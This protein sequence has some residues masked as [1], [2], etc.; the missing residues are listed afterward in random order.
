MYYYFGEFKYF[1]TIVINELS[2]YFKANPTAI[3][4]I[5]TYHDYAHILN[6]L[7]SKNVQVVSINL[8]PERI[9]HDANIN[10]SHP[11]QPTNLVDFL[12][13]RTSLSDY[14]TNIN[15]TKYKAINKYKHHENTICVLPYYRDEFQKGL[16]FSIRN[17]TIDKYN[18][19]IEI[20]KDTFFGH[21]YNIVLV[22]NKN[23]HLKNIDNK[24][25][26]VENIDEM[27][28]LMNNCKLLVS[29]ECGF[30]EFAKNCGVSNILL[31]HTGVYNANNY[32]YNPHNSN[33]YNL[34]INDKLTIPRFRLDYCYSVLRKPQPKSARPYVSCI[35]PTYNRREFLP[36]LCE[37]FNMQTY[38]NNSKELIIIDDSPQNNIDIIPN[39]SNIRYYHSL[40]KMTIGKKRNIINQLI[41][42]DIVVCF[43]D[44][45]YYPVDRISHA[46]TKLQGAKVNLAGATVI[47]IYYTDL[48][49]IY[50]FGPY[51]P[52][53]GTN[54]TMAYTI[55]Q[56]RD[57]HYDDDKPYAEEAFF[58]SN[59]T[60][61][62]V[63][64][65]PHKVML[66][67]AHGGNTFN[68]KKIIKDGK[69]QKIKLN[70]F[71]KNKKLL[72]FYK[73][74]RLK[75]AE[76]AGI[77]PEVVSVGTDN[78][79]VVADNSNILSNIMMVN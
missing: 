68:K 9:F 23:E 59:F 67:M 2:I 48:D 28:Y 34:N 60:V 42:G 31:I 18:K 61:P 44:D 39:Q 22:G 24:L 16:D 25:Q 38:P 72:K 27:I 35:C 21:D 32:K 12:K 79:T 10:V 14:T 74:L 13:C 5:I 20:I 33:L 46:V 11:S 77:T 29:P 43:D 19:A 63:Q 56:M 65:D 62:L 54:G 64:L 7:F 40:V 53:H 57:H 50:Q 52:N 47:Y 1:N 58:T 51:A 30:I 37:I 75:A 71:I 6:M 55:Q 15:I 49:K 41:N 66:C 17:M 8:A 36:N 73:N 76:G 26:V 45:D 70:N 3:L 4:D 69:E 78:K